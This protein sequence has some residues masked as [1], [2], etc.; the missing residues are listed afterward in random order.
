MWELCPTGAQLPHPLWVKQIM[1]PIVLFL[2]S[3]CL[4]KTLTRI[5]HMTLVNS[6]Q[7]SSSTQVSCRSAIDSIQ[8]VLEDHG[9]E[10]RLSELFLSPM[11]V[12]NVQ[13]WV[14]LGNTN[15]FY[16]Q[17]SNARFDVRAGV[18]SEGEGVIDIVSCVEEVDVVSCEV[19]L[20]YNSGV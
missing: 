17:D 16:C 7:C 5:Q 6:L 14:T 12:T 9:F 8:P 2:L 3:N 1:L 10:I 19:T 13:N 4:N 11:L 20:Y 15:L 18:N